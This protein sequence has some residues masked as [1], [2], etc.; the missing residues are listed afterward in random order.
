MLLRREFFREDDLDPGREPG[1]EPG[2]VGVG[3]ILT[4]P[5]IF[6]GRMLPQS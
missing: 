6:S 1:H 3:K 5:G 2:G 4:A